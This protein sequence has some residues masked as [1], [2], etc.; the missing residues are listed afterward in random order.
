[1]VIMPIKMMQ[2][3]SP[4]GPESSRA[5]IHNYQFEIIVEMDG[6]IGDTSIVVEY[7][8][9]DDCADDDELNRNFS[10]AKETKHF[11]LLSL[12]EPTNI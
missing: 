5:S 4:A 9:T 12:P 11:G 8:F 10:L 2:R 3:I 6:K 7:P 1:M